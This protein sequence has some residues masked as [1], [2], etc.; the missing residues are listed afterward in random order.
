MAWL[1]KWFTAL[2]YIR[3][4]KGVLYNVAWSSRLILIFH[5]LLRQ[6][7]SILINVYYTYIQISDTISVMAKTTGRAI[8]KLQ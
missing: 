8:S 7:K 5:Y 3:E 2:V 6:W 1:Y 4:Q